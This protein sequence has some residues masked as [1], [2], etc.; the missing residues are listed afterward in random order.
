MVM[1]RANLKQLAPDPQGIE[2]APSISPEKRM[3]ALVEAV[4][5]A[6]TPL[7][8]RSA[9][10]LLEGDLNLKIGGR[11]MRR[12]A[13]EMLARTALDP[14]MGPINRALV[15]GVLLNP[16]GFWRCCALGTL[17]MSRS[18]TPLRFIQS[19]TSGPFSV[20]GKGVC[21]K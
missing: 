4:R 19:S 7:A 8:A 9:G 6:D 14:E 21:E 3:A 5:Q 11:L 18:C 20:T 1:T 12:P 16:G 2:A 15:R 13:Y 17:S 10:L